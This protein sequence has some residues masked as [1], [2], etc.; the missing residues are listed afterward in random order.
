MS[1]SDV[2]RFLREE[3]SIAEYKIDLLKKGPNKVYKARLIKKELAF[4]EYPFG[5]LG[6]DSLE[7]A[8]EAVLLF[9]SD[10][11]LFFEKYS[12]KSFD[13]V[14]LSTI[15]NVLDKKIS[16]YRSLYKDILEKKIQSISLAGGPDIA[17][18]RSLPKD[19]DGIDSV[20]SSEGVFAAKARARVQI[21]LYCLARTIYHRLSDVL[22]LIEKERALEEPRLHVL[23]SKLDN[24]IKD[25][26]LDIF[27]YYNNGIREVPLLVNGTAG[28]NNFLNTIYPLIN[29]F[30]KH[31]G[32]YFL[33]RTLNKGRV[34]FD[35]S[36]RPISKK[37]AE[38]GLSI[39]TPINR[40]GNEAVN[41]L[42]ADIWTSDGVCITSIIDN[43]FF[44]YNKGGKYYKA[45]STK[46][47]WEIIEKQEYLLFEKE[48]SKII[49]ED[50]SSIDC[51]LELKK[52]IN[53][54]SGQGLSISSNLSKMLIGA[55]RS[56]T[57]H[58]RDASAYI[59]LLISK[60]KD[61]YKDIFK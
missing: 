50:I 22:E 35:A 45:V 44:N 33:K 36:G 26:R 27:R 20:S 48:I 4:I 13:K 59:D 28:H 31:P 34:F 11:H 16:F 19:T 8:R 37:F 53:R 38:R 18:K 57:L 14:A 32:E 23:N 49:G 21:L 24:I 56:E 25:T 54:S 30:E 41:L 51:D 2:E 39:I 47:I 29:V 42:Y 10:P 55:T 15:N 58:I 52:K 9:R 43:K 1:G 61:E 6:L 12:N 3:K 46:P 40:V 7:S 5:S 17:T 60:I